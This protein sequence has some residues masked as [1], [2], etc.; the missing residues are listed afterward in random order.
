MPDF[1]DQNVAKCPVPELNRIWIEDSFTWMI[2]HFGQQVLQRP[3]L[4]PD[5]NH[6]PIKFN[7]QLSCAE[8]AMKIIAH[9][10]EVSPEIVK[11]HVYQEGLREIAMGTGRIF[12]EQVDGQKYSSG[13]YHGSDD[14]GLF[15]I[16]LEKKT[17]T[18]P[19]KLIAVLAH[20]LAHIKL[21]GEKRI[22]KNNEHLTDLTTVF[23]G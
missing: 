2:S 6:F 15:H 3:L 9:Q 11:L 23:L 22:K 13:L 14:D 20:E 21:L 17:L 1:T 4:V 16:G 5:V 7:G 8:E 10:M 18:D 19:E 12:L